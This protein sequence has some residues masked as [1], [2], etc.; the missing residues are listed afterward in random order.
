[1]TPNTLCH[2]LA[3][4]LFRY[5]VNLFRYTTPNFLSLTM[6]TVILPIHTKR[7]RG[8]PHSYF[9]QIVRRSAFNCITGL[10]FAAESDNSKSH[11]ES[12]SCRM[13][14]W[15]FSHSLKADSLCVAAVDEIWFSSNR[16]T[17]RDIR[18]AVRC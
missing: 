7:Q 17:T 18:L 5:A 6:S 1:M 8:Q 15:V 14:R 12:Q 2:D 13:T 4:N 16:D 10:V 3:V 9:L 11:S